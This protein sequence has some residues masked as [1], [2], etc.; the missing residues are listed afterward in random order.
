MDYWKN[1]LSSTLAS[2]VKV[3]LAS[4]ILTGPVQVMSENTAPLGATESRR[5]CAVESVTE[6][7][8]TARLFD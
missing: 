4:P 1:V 3:I 7:A 2:P 5:A 6:E 8:V